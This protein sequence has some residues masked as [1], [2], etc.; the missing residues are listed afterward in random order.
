M[1]L[2]QVWW[3]DPIDAVEQLQV[4]FYL[5]MCFQ[6]KLITWAKLKTSKTCTHLLQGIKESLF[7][8]LSH[9]LQI[10]DMWHITCDMWHM[11]CDTWYRTCDTWHVHVTY[12]MWHR[13]HGGGW[14]FSQNFSSLALTIWAG[15][16]F[17]D[18]EENVDLSVWGLSL[19][20]ELFPIAPMKG[21]RVGA[22]YIQ[23]THYLP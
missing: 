2:D 19:V 20:K 10:C 22:A 4:Q 5:L 16:W 23:N 11:R 7:G 15:K 17:E 14:T 6:Q 12:D 3:E 9:L 18:L 8:K 21:P 13:T 1:K